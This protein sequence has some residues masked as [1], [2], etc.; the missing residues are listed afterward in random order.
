MSKKR[1]SRTKYYLGNCGIKMIRKIVFPEDARIV[2]LYMKRFFSTIHNT[3]KELPWVNFL[4]SIICLRHLQFKIRR[5][6]R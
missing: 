1:K 4:V 2:L 5:A 3:I 6:E